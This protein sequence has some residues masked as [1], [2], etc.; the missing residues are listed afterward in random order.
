MDLRDCLVTGLVVLAAW[1][2]QADVEDLEEDLTCAPPVALEVLDQAWECPV[3]QEAAVCQVVE[4]HP[5]DR[6]DPS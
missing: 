5:W 2:R 4:V 1:D 3:D 6:L